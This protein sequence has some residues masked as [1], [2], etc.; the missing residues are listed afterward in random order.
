MED[1][2]SWVRF[3]QELSDDMAEIGKEGRNRET[4]AI[5]LETHRGGFG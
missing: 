1:L 3:E 2:Y 5:I 4:V